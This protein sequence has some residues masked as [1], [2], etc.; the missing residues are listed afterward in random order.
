MDLLNKL[1]EINDNL[2]LESKAKII[3]NIDEEDDEDD[4]EY[5]TSLRENFVKKYNKVNNRQFKLNNKRYYLDKYSKDVIDLEGH[6]RGRKG[7]NMIF[8]SEE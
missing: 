7:Y 5:I 8:Q 3:Y 6:I 1:L 4:I 2:Y